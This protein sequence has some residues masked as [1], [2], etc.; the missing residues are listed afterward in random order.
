MCRAM[1]QGTC[2]SRELVSGLG[3]L[4]T[5]ISVDAVDVVVDESGANT[6]GAGTWASCSVV[7][8]VVVAG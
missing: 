7:V 3:R 8:A 1:P 6:T 2:R 5:G 4:Y